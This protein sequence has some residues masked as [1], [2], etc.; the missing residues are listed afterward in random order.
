MSA[1]NKDRLLRLEAI[2]EKQRRLRK[3]KPL[4]RPHRGQEE[5]HKSEARIRFVTS[6]NGSGKTCQA[7]QEALAWATGYNHVTEKYTKV[8]AT[9]IVLL[10]NPLKVDTPWLNEIRKWYDVDGQCELLKNGKPYVNEIKFKNGSKIIFMF[11]A[12]ESLVFEGIELDYLIADE[13]FPR[14]AWIGLQRGMRTKKAKPRSLIIGTP[15]GQP[16]MYEE[17]YKP[18][19]DGLR[20]DIEV[21]N[22]ATEANRENLA[23]GYIEDF[24]QNLT[25]AEIETRLF[26]KFSH[27][28]GLAL[29]NL[30]KKDV[31]VIKPFDWPKNWPTV[32]ALDPHPAKNHVACLLGASPKGRYYY[33]R[34]WSIKG[35]ATDVARTLKA[36]LKGYQVMDVICDSLGSTPGSGGEGRMSFIEKLN[37]QGLRCRATDFKEKSDSDW[38]ERI[39][40]VLR[41]PDAPDQ[42]YQKLPTLQIF[43][44]NKGLISNI[45]TVQWQK[46]RTGGYVEKLDISRTDFLACL[47]YAL[48]TN[49][50]A[51]AQLGRLP[52]ARKSGRSPWSGP[53]RANY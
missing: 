12:Q 15:L 16:W 38:L 45:E 29:A 44:G 32:V 40:Q 35:D 18:A 25:E 30:F 52:T 17:I 51:Y 22:F 4:Y 41:I 27:L 14:H 24:Q 19:I 1:A 2:K 10:D 20:P 53:K 7:V 37:E 8:P 9:I 48:A 31:H 5:V 46:Q 43:Q 21:F 13:P 3:A 28:E 23:D 6:G 49:I 26:G 33:I 34:E 50:G 11:H 39:R 42:L 36:D 47:K